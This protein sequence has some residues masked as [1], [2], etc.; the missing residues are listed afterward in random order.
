MLFKFLGE[1]MR[2]TVKW[3]SEAKGYGFILDENKKEYFVHWKSILTLEN[4]RKFLQEGEAVE[5]DISSTEK[6]DQAV[7][8]VRLNI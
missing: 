1:V 4:Y 7:N 2:G 5:F 6:G 3:F 8:V